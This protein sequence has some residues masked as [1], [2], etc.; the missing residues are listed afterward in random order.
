MLAIV[1]AKVLTA[2]RNGGPVPYE[3]PAGTVLIDEETGKIAAVGGPGLA[4]P[5]GARIL[6]AQGCIVTPGFIDAHSHI[7]IYEDGLGWEGNDTN[8]GTDPNTADVRALDGINPADT[9]FAEALEGGVTTVQVMPGSANIIGGDI[10]TI[11]CVGKVADDMVL[12]RSTG[13]KAALGE[14]PKRYYGSQR[15]RPSTRM[16]SAAVMR[17]ALAKAQDYLRKKETAAAKGDPPPDADLKLEMIGRVLRREIPMR[18]H[19]HRADDI[20]T[21]VRI[22]DEFGIDI[23]IE[24][25]T[26]ADRIAPLLAAKGIPCLFGPIGGPRSKLE[27]KDRGPHIPAALHAAGVKF[28]LIC[29]HPIIPQ[30]WL[31][32]GAGLCIREGLSDRAA[33]EACTRDAAEI[34]GVADRVGTLEPG[35]DADV[36]IWDGDPFEYL[37]RARCVLVDGKLVHCTCAGTCAASISAKDSAAV[38]AAVSATKVSAKNRGC[39][40]C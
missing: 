30:Q 7:G 36:V 17:G 21:A 28:G 12:A 24:H 35:K 10:V 29:D 9:A 23:T 2:C 39:C 3:L 37:T 16:G 5:D 27:N 18:V 15:K 20:L 32:I 33:L 22:R 14:N 11:K 4:V 8:E 13:L 34:I 1:G 31:R 6:E 25:A 26:E 38:S 19:A 40:G